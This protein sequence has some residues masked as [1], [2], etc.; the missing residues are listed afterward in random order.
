MSDKDTDWGCCILLTR[1]KGL[2][3]KPTLL[4]SQ[5][6]ERQSPEDLASFQTQVCLEIPSSKSQNSLFLRKLMEP[7]F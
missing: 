5:E 2:R 6:M 3:M 4:E 1:G 7:S